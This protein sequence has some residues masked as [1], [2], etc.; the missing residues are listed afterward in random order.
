MLQQIGEHP[1][2][3]ILILPLLDLS[4]VDK[5]KPGK[6]LEKLEDYFAPMWIV[7]Y[8]QYLFHSAQQ[9]ANKTID[10]YIIHLR[11]LAEKTVSHCM[12]KCYKI[13]SY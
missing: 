9:Q 11:H 13:A 6:I 10:Q 7:L 2:K 1:K 4:D 3:P 8:E 12:I 5:K